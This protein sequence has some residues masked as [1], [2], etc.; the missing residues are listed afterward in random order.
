MLLCRQHGQRASECLAL[1][2]VPQARTPA[3]SGT[4]RAPQ[5]LH[6][7]S[8]LT[9]Q[10][11][12]APPQPEETENPPEGETPPGSEKENSSEDDLMDMLFF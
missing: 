2:P 12:E 10:T 4:K 6:E 8:H 9:H 11:D 7:E 3:T 5:K 1:A